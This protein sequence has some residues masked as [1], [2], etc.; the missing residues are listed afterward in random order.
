MERVVHKAYSFEESDH[1]DVQQQINLTYSQ[2][3]H[4]ARLLKERVYG[5]DAKDAR[6]CH[7]K[8]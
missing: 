2:R 3:L 8:K 4:A 6:A 5:K 7:Q 1:Y